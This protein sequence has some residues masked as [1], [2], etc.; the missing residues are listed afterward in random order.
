[1]SKKQDRL[2]IELMVHEYL[3]SGGKIKRGRAPKRNAFNSSYLYIRADA[4]YRGAKSNGLRSM[5]Y[6]KAA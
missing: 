2:E 6:A 1:M 3:S 5:G 4:A